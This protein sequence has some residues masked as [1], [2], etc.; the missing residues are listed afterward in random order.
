MPCQCDFLTERE[1][2]K[3]NQQ[4]SILISQLRE[5]KQ[6]EAKANQTRVE[7]EQQ[8]VALF[9]PQSGEATVKQDDLTITYK[10][11]R[12]VDSACVQQAWNDMTSTSQ[13]AFKVKFD[14]DLKQYRAISELDAASAAIINRFITSKPAKPSI[15]LKETNGI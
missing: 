10:T 9:P 15:T 11:T 12:S 5:A 7:I 6:V 4:L 2:T 8:I 3:V 1:V 14:L 13:T